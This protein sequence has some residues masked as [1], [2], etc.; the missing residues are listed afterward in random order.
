[1]LFPIYFKLDG[2]VPSIHEMTVP[3][4]TIAVES[5]IFICTDITEAFF[6]SLS[7]AFTC[8]LYINIF[9]C[10]Y[11]FIGF[12]TPSFYI[13]ENKKFIRYCILFCILFYLGSFIF[14]YLL[15]PIFTN[16][17][18]FSGFSNYNTIVSTNDHNFS[19]TN[20]LNMPHSGCGTNGIEHQVL[21]ERTVH[22]TMLRV[23]SYIYFITKFFLFTQFFFEIPFLITLLLKLEVINF[24]GLIRNRRIFYIGILL[25]I[26]LLSPPDLVFQCSASLFFILSLEIYFLFWFITLKYQRLEL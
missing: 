24:L 11:H 4:H 21:T 1:L 23:S 26:A 15:Y 3:S 9:F 14:I 5:P 22:K 6:T 8:T 25:V 13:Q 7:L 12:F 10:I 16:F 2:G 19:G 18:I 20:G 17:L